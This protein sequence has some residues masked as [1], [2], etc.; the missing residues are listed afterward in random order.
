MPCL[1][2]A[3]TAVRQGR[4]AHAGADDMGKAV[5]T[6][7]LIDRLCRVIAVLGML[8]RMNAADSPRPRA[9]RSQAGEPAR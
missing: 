6:D 7:E 1:V 2:C 3:A 5:Q 4:R 9:G 8:E